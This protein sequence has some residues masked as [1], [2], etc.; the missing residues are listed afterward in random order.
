[1]SPPE[2]DK[3]DRTVAPQ[4]AAELGV[5]YASSAGLSTGE[6][7]H[8]D[9]H[10]DV[11]PIHPGLDRPL[12]ICITGYRSAPFGGGQ[13]IYIKY[14]SKALVDAGHN[15]D[16]I[17]G[18]PYPHLDPR[19]RLIKMP[20]LDLF[21]NGLGSLRPR[22]LKSL[23]NIIE[24]TSKL[25]GGFA[26]PYCFSRRLAKYLDTHGHRYDIVHDNQCLGWGMLALQQRGTSLL[27]TIHHPVTS[28]LAIALQAARHWWE[29]ILIHRWHFFLRMQKKV[30]SQLE[31]VVTVSH[32]SR[33]D[34]A[35]AFDLDSRKIHLVYNGI[36]TDEFRP[37]PEVA[38]RRFQIMATA[39]ADQPLKGLRYLLL[40]V[41]RLAKKYP[42][43]HLL[44]VSKP[45]PGGPT[46][47]LIRRLKLAGHVTF[48]SGISTE[49]MVEHYAQSEI[50][51]VPSVYEGFGLPAG[52]AM[53]CGVPVVSTDGG[54]LAEVVG[55][56]GIVVPTKEAG[57]LADSIE[58][59]LLDEK[60]RQEYAEAGRDRIEKHFCWRLAAQQMTALYCG[61][62]DADG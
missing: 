6:A 18:Q 25:T 22:H 35:D 52:E 3:L 20:G 7:Q 21:A 16:V 43:I 33:A 50:A 58:K 5:E 23:T 42:Q 15:V 38:K 17:S 62:M 28:D 56:A 54:A 45:K 8:A 55:D 51:V 49:E 47:K 19:V 32:R 40:A 53:A 4:S 39:S 9:A 2:P 11:V 37:M 1:M 61:V 14:L 26:E 34:I 29:K 12:N 31:H 44:L 13:G 30:A 24:W 36:D 27:T 59:L 41:A 48:V 60:L 57:A 46:E 10:A